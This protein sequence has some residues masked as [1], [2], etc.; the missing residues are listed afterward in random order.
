MAKEKIIVTLY[1]QIKISTASDPDGE[2]EPSKNWIVKGIDPVQNQFGFPVD[3]VKGP[4]KSQKRAIQF[5]KAYADR[6]G[7]QFV[8]E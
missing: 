3:L 2:Y 8:L 1:K 7:Y 4:F 6:H 5:G